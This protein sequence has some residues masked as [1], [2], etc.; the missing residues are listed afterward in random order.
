MFKNYNTQFTTLLVSSLIV[1]VSANLS[2][3]T[4]NDVNYNEPKYFAYENLE[5]NYI[6]D[7]INTNFEIARNLHFDFLNVD[8]KLD[9]EIDNYFS[10]YSGSD[11]EIVEI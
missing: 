2:S 8:E 5:K 11:I 10:N 9:K 7:F 1:N 3:V 4:F 6:T